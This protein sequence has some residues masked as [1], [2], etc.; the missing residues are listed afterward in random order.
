MGQIRRTFDIGFKIKV[1]QA[2]EAGEKTVLEIYRQYQLQ[3]VVVEGW[4]QKFVQ[5]ELKAK[6]IESPEASLVRENEKLKAKVGELT[7]QIDLLKKFA[8]ELNHPSTK[9]GHSL[10]YT[11]GNMEVKSGLVK[12]VIYL[13]AP[14]IT[15]KKKKR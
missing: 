14:T 5:G 3:R 12:P 9:N 8:K 7:M 10:I 15:G 13:P 11:G 6:G 2:I 1:C 4:F